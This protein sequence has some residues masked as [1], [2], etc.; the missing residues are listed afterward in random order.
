MPI[1]KYARL[2]RAH[3]APLE[4]VPA[5]VGALLATGGSITIQVIAWGV[6]GVLYHLTGYG[7]NS[8][9][10]WE[11]GYDRDDPHKKHHPLN[12]GEIKPE[13]AVAFIMV[14]AVVTLIHVIVLSSNSL[15]A[16]ALVFVMVFSGAAYNYFGKITTL[17]FIPISVAH[18]LVFVIPYIA[19][20]GEINQL[21]LL[22]TVYMFLW[23]AFQISVSGEL[24]DFW[25]DEANF[26]K[27]I[28]R[29]NLWSLGTPA[30]LYALVL[31]ASSLEIIRIVSK[32][33]GRYIATVI[34]A[35]LAVIF[36]VL[37]LATVKSEDNRGTI[38]KSMAMI[39]GLMLIGLVTSVF[40]VL[41]QS[42]SIALI[43]GAVLWLVTFNYLEWGTLLEPK[44]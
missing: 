41:G 37:M 20:G 4:A 9:T 38:V 7:M 42:L 21:F 6:F 29:G 22:L 40:H 30:I 23:I 17:K 27:R 8:Y 15:I 26:L 14:L 35:A 39:E 1:A 19:M 43:V 10:D 31:K 12:T 25:T 13:D 36:T 18:S 33:H 11:A 3:T 2:T 16:I 44:V 24:K 28:R 5:L 32:E 34:V